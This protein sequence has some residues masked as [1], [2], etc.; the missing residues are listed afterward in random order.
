MRKADVFRG[1]GIAGALLFAA[2][3]LDVILG[4]APDAVH[5]IVGLFGLTL[6]AVSAAAGAGWPEGCPRHRSHRGY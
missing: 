4:G 6:L 5:A 1:A 2:P 3:V